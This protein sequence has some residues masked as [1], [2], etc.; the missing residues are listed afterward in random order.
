MT[1][2]LGESANVEDQSSSLGLEE[3]TN[4]SAQSGLMLPPARPL[5]SHKRASTS[6]RC[7]LRSKV[8][9]GGNT[10]NKKGVNE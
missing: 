10:G 6:K 3:L 5:T 1:D 2:L 9:G 4:S 8:K 7:L